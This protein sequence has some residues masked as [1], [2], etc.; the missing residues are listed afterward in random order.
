MMS[1]PASGHGN[2]ATREER[3]SNEVKTEAA[4]MMKVMN[5]RARNMAQHDGARRQRR[6]SKSKS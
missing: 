6:E 1:E 5:G 4:F 2:A 3:E